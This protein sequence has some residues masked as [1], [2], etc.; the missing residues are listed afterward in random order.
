MNK[1][2]LVATSKAILQ[3]VSARHMSVL[4]KAILDNSF[5]DRSLKRWWCSSTFSQEGTVES[6]CCNMSILCDAHWEDTDI[7]VTRCAPDL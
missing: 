3:G 1:T 7:P 2:Y 6:D 4:R 5:E